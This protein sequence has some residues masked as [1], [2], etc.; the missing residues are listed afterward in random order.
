MWLQHCK[1]LQ[2]KAKMQ[3]TVS[4]YEIKLT[5]DHWS[6]QYPKLLQKL[7]TPK[8]ISNIQLLNGL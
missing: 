8:Q 4:I 3:T 2:I 6:F 7:T 1:W 5:A